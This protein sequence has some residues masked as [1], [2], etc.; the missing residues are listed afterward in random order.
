M[1]TCTVC[2]Q[3]CIWENERGEGNPNTVIVHMHSNGACPLKEVYFGDT[4]ALSAEVYLG[5]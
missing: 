5:L 4:K 1:V 2:V 3:L